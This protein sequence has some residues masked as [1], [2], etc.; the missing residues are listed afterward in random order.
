MVT[1][2]LP[3]AASL[4]PLNCRVPALLPTKPTFFPPEQAEQFATRAPPAR[5][6]LADSAS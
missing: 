1:V 3:A 4:T 2:A 6:L 5:V